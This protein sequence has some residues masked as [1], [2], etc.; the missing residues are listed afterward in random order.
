MASGDDEQFARELLQQFAV[1]AFRGEQPNSKF[2]DRLVQRYAA[3][4]AK[5]QSRTDAMI[6]S[7]SIILASPSFLYMVESTGNE[8]F[9]SLTGRELAVRLSYFLWS[10]PPDDELLSLARNGKL[11]N[12]TVL[13][14]QTSRLLEDE[15]ADRFVRGFVHQWLEM[16][17]LGMFQ[18]DGVQFRTF[19]NAARE[20]AG[21]EVFQTVHT[22]LDEQLPLRSLL[23]SDFVVVNDLLAGYYGIPGVVGHEFRKVKVAEDSLRGGLLGSAAVLA[24]GSD[25]QR[26]SL[27]ERGA[28]VLRHLLNDAPPPAPPNVPMLSRLAGQVLSARELGKAHQEE[29]Q[30]AQCHQKIDPIG[31]GLENF[32]A[33][34]LWRDSETIIIGKRKATKT[35]EFDIDPSGQLPGGEKFDDYFELR[36]AV[37]KY[38]DSF[39]RGFTESLIAYGLG[40]PFGFTDQDLADELLSKA[41]PNDYELSAFVHA[42]IQSKAFQ[43][44]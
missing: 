36:D 25:G 37:S 28:W 32:N 1:R 23:K 19:D 6:G 20:S 43:T 27:V 30:C 5:G 38:E 24:M 13:T 40:R 42:L 39:A 34:G 4:R 22:L 29:P 44:K 33:A 2:V 31:F 16:E 21:E 18:F 11:S 15:R 7:L 26:S 12:P 3:N 17:R 35:K 9:P 14:A 10:A 8:S 41:K